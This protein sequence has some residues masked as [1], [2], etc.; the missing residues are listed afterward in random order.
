MPRP[1]HPETR[2]ILRE[3]WPDHGAWSTPKFKRLEYCSPMTIQKKLDILRGGRIPLRYLKPTILLLPSK[4][5]RGTLAKLQ[6][7][8]SK[9][10]ALYRENEGLAIAEATK[11]NVRGLTTDDKRTIATEALLDAALKYSPHKGAFSTFATSVIQ[12]RFLDELRVQARRGKVDTSLRDQARKGHDTLSR[13][14]LSEWVET[15]LHKGL[16]EELRALRIGKRP[17]S[18]VEAEVVL[19]SFGIDRPKQTLDEIAEEFGSTKKSIKLTKNRVLRHWRKRSNLAGY[20][21]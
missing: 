3:M 4:E 20:L 6:S 13:T 10:L 8:V 11:A 21:S 1:V 9:K 7:N 19:R 15:E 12:R 16:V 5:I 14:P 18:F 17:I 2:R